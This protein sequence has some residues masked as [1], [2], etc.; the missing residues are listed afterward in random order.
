MPTN[1]LQVQSPDASNC[2]PSCAPLRDPNVAKQILENAKMIAAGEVPHRIVSP[3][4]SVQLHKNVLSTL[5]PVM[6]LGFNNRNR[7][8]GTG[9]PIDLTPFVTSLEMS[10]SVNP[11]ALGSCSVSLKAEYLGSLDTHTTQKRLDPNDNNIEW[12]DE[13]EDND[14]ILVHLDCGI[15][16]TNVDTQDGVMKMS[17]GTQLDADKSAVSRAQAERN[18]ILPFG[19]GHGK[20]S[21][22]FFGFVDSVQ[23]VRSANGTGG[24]TVVYTLIC[25]DF[26]KA[27]ESNVKFLAV[28][29]L[30]KNLEERIKALLKI[31]RTTRGSV[32]IPPEMAA[33]AIAYLLLGGRS[34][35]EEDLATLKEKVEADLRQQRTPTPSGAQATDAVSEDADETVKEYQIAEEMS[36]LIG[37][38]TTGLENLDEALRLSPRQ[39]LMPTSL[40][41]E[42][43]TFDSNLLS[44]LNALLPLFHSVGGVQIIELMQV[45]TGYASYNY[46]VRGDQY[47]AYLKGESNEAIMSGQYGSSPSFISIVTNALQSIYAENDT[48]FKTVYELIVE[49]ISTVPEE[50]QFFFDLRDFFGVAP[51]VV[52]LPTIVCNS[53]AKPLQLISQSERT[54]YNDSLLGDGTEMQEALTSAYGT[55]GLSYL[56]TPINFIMDSDLI[57]EV[58]V[59]DGSQRRTMSGVTVGTR[60]NAAAPAIAE[61]YQATDRS[62]AS[63]G[64][65][66]YHNKQAELAHGF[67]PYYDINTDIIDRSAITEDGEA[68]NVVN[69]ANVMFVAAR[70]RT[71]ISTIELRGTLLSSVLL[72][73]ARVGERIAVFRSDRRVPP[74]EEFK[75]VYEENSIIRG[76][77]ARF[78]DD[79]SYFAPSADPESIPETPPTVEDVI[80]RFK[81]LLSNS[82]NKSRTGRQLMLQAEKEVTGTSTPDKED[83]GFHLFHGAERAW[84]FAHF[85]CFCIDEVSHGI[86]INAQDG[87]LEATTSLTVSYGALGREYPKISSEIVPTTNTVSEDLKAAQVVSELLRDPRFKELSEQSQLRNVRGRQTQVE[88]SESVIRSDEARAEY[89]ARLADRAQ[90]L[91]AIGLASDGQ[92]DRAVWNGIEQS[93]SKI[94]SYTSAYVLSQTLSRHFTVDIAANT[95]VRTAQLQ[96]D[97]DAIS[98]VPAEQVRFPA[99]F[100]GRAYMLQTGLVTYMVSQSNTVERT[101]KSPFTALEATYDHPS[102]LVSS[103]GLKAAITSATAELEARLIETV[104]RANQIM[105]DFHRNMPSE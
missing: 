103:T 77:N 10:K 62:G 89:Q 104:S 26:S 55:A 40:T 81:I 57:S 32:D 60:S 86:D 23:R 85:D 49:A 101:V 37:K 67:K 28:D 72:P 41:E 88:R 73:S 39:F 102:G 14:I 42:E 90:R 76:I 98:D 34:V 30:G 79:F 70:D 51:T 35:T 94:R 2:D 59:K 18:T 25:S 47:Q 27:F 13:I 9:E 20:S 66:L 74:F 80:A 54:S 56:N 43:S 1:L 48:E 29:D 12:L 31:Q 91:R 50:V 11:S 3:R 78:A 24:Q 33:T 8:E 61:V 105:V 53:Y 92:D 95:V 5:P 96:T 21:L 69:F 16:Q 64:N 7:G 84:F 100:E 99:H 6:P 22:A 45:L 19:R 82:A 44:Q 38:L 71:L 83:A 58:L 97:L 75:K 17:F 4:F 52:T 36:T 15:G 63:L 65:P 93:D 87:S 68:A 46:T